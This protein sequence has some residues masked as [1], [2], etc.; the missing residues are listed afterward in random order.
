MFAGLLVN[1]GVGVLV[2]LKTNK[3]AME[4]L[5]IVTTLFVLGVLWGVLIEFT[6]L[7]F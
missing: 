4:N 7:V 2:L 5:A 1:A 3:S 6:G